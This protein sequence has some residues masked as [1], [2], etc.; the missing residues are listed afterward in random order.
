MSRRSSVLLAVLAV[1]VGL[2]AVSAGEVRVYRDGWGVPHI[3][4]STDTDVMYGFGYA[5]A[6]DRLAD[7]LQNVLSATGRMAEAFG[8][9]FVELDF[10]RRLWAHER[11]SRDRYLELSEDV[12]GLIEAYCAGI[13]T[14]MRDNPEAVP[15]WGFV[16]QPHQIVAV[17]RSVVWP[18]MLQQA[19][20]EHR[21]GPPPELQSNQ[22]VVARER[23]A[24]DAVILCIDPHTEWDSPTR[25]YEAHLHGNRINAFGFTYPGL[26]VFLIGH[27]DHLGWAPL[28]AA[29]TQPTSMP[30]SSNRLPPGGSDTA[31][32]G[33]P[34]TPTR[35][36][37]LSGAMAPLEPP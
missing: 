29:R 28:R 8:P 36:T 33:V 35:S 27:N 11:T 1:L 13:A 21:G 17:G 16:P 14:C 12:R 18:H 20:R 2:S 15:D 19:E 25:W 7:L 31:T 22:W 4:G 5:Q 10:Q 32:V 37:S 26:P 23:T 9:D 6:E 24:E 30:S 34:S 3:H